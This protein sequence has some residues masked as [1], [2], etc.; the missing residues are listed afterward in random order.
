[1]AGGL[2]FVNWWMGDNGR[3]GSGLLCHIPRHLHIH[4]CDSL[5]FRDGRAQGT[6]SSS[7]NRTVIVS[8]LVHREEASESTRLCCY[9]GEGLLGEEEEEGISSMR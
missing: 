5:P 7:S 9:P 2:N 4:T 8:P 6:T 1:M 3:S